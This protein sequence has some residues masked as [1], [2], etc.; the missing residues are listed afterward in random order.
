MDVPVTLT[1]FT[2]SLSLVTADLTPVCFGPLCSLV[3][4]FHFKLSS[5]VN[6]LYEDCPQ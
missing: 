1:A 3:A 6:R 2:F 4:V 5:H